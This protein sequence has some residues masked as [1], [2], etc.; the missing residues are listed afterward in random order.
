MRARLIVAPPTV[1]LTLSYQDA[2]ILLTLIS[3]TALHGGVGRVLNHII[4]TLEGVSIPYKNVGWTDEQ[5]E[6]LST[7]AR[8]LS[9][10]NLTEFNALEDAS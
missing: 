1:E 3:L 8:P 2:Q 10:M 9:D 7:A 4:D 5:H 6:A